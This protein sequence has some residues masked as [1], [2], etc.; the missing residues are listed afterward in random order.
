MHRLSHRAI[1]SS[2]FLGCAAGGK[3]SLGPGVS[4]T[5]LT[6]APDTVTLDPGA[7]AQ[8]SATGKYSDG[9]TG[10]VTVGWSATGG[11]ISS[12]GLYQA[13][14]TGG[15]Y[16]VVA[17]VTGQ[18][19]ADSGRVT[20]RDTTTQPSGGTVLFSEGFDDANVGS[21]GWYD[22][23]HPAISTSDFHGGTG[24]LQM[25]WQQ[26]ALLPAQGGALRHKFTPTDRVYLRYW[27]KYSDNY[28]GSGQ[29][30]HP[31]EFYFVT[32]AETDDY[33]GPSVTH[34][35]TYVEQ[36]YLNGGR[37]QLGMTDVMNIDTTQINVDLTNITENRASAGCNGSADGYHTDCYFA[38]GQ[39]Q[40]EK[41]WRAATPSFLPNPGPGYKGNWN[42]VEAYYQINSIVNGI[43]QKDGVAQYWFNG[44]AIIDNHN[45][46]F[47]TGAHP[48]MKFD[49]FLIAPYIGD[50]SPVAQTFWIDDVVVAT[51]KVP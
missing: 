2:L 3:E 5:G 1:I 7:S 26:G 24:S 12:G 34:L 8:F 37:P 39:W 9:S 29:N 50:G 4:L 41:I 21:R 10:S 14:P 31:H 16:L 17:K 19:L 35:T 11:A 6:I 51:S 36:N 25:A 28:I 33:I 27:V 49:M 43:G 13:G 32:D 15:A 48:N 30:Y 38:G 42:L 20:I 45:V 46:V 40:N 44:Q 22:N 47:R 23:T 18:S